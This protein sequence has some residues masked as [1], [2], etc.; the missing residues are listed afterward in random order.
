MPFRLVTAN[1]RACGQLTYSQGD[2]SGR[3]LRWVVVE[4]VSKGC[5]D[6]LPVSK[7]ADLQHLRMEERWPLTHKTRTAERAG[8]RGSKAAW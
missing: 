2:G 5:Q 6:T 7:Q 4:T 3:F 1:G 8:E